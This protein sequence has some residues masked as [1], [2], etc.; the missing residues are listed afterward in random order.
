MTAPAIILR[1]PADPS[2]TA[3]APPFKDDGSAYRFEMI[4]DGGK[5][6]AYADDAEALLATLIR[7]YDRMDEPARLTARLHLAVRT[8]TTTQADI[9]AYYGTDSLTPDEYAILMASRATPPQITEWTSEVPIVL[10]DVFYT[11]MGDLPRPVG[12]DG[13][14]AEPANIFWLRPTDPYDL[15]ESLHGI[16]AIG[17]AQHN[18][19]VV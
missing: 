9:C 14:V 7:G 17:L 12:P 18:D 4:Y 10:V 15:L 11:P 5:Y 1:N 13:D 6:R 8:Q 16:G 19:F 2:E 3:P